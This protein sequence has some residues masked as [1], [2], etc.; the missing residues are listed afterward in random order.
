MAYDPELQPV[1]YSPEDYRL[2]VAT[3]TRLGNLVLETP[4]LAL[5]VLTNPALADGTPE[6]AIRSSTDAAIMRLIGSTVRTLLD[7][8]AH[9]LNLYFQPSVQ[10]QIL[11]DEDVRSALAGLSA[12][13]YQDDQASITGVREVGRARLLAWARLVIASQ[14]QTPSNDEK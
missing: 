1:V 11:Q 13:E 14:D 4:S 7:Q 12:I 2:T 3:L 5:A 10:V 8:S 9:G 6:R